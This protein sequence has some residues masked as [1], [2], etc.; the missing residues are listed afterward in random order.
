MT[1]ENIHAHLAQGATV[2]RAVLDGTNEILKPA[3]LTLLCVLSVFI[4]SF[5]MEGVTRALFIPL[6][7]SVGF[8]MISSFVLSRTLVP[9]LSAKMLKGHLHEEETFFD[10][11]KLGYTQFIKK[12]IPFKKTF[13]FWIPLDR[14]RCG[15]SLSDEYWWRNL[16]TS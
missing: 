13:L 14:I 3:L 1:I 10:R 12:I 11:W 9:I 8:S 16:P 4:P 5:F 6:T 2:A 15:F 7:L